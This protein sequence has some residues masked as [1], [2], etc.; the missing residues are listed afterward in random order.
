MAGTDASDTD[1]ADA[2]VDALQVAAADAD[3]TDTHAA[4]AH[5]DG[6]GAAQSDVHAAAADDDDD[7]G[8]ADDAVRQATT[9]YA[10]SGQAKPGQVVVTPNLP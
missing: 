7:A 9:R 3:A 1:A 4:H 2:G 10:K 6:V 8:D 5:G